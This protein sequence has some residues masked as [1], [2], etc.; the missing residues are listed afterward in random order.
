MSGKLQGK[1][2]LVT[3]GNKRHWLHDGRSRFVAAEGAYALITG[4]HVP[5][6][7]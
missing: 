3:S 2:A 4:R 1:V 7:L 6:E 5:R